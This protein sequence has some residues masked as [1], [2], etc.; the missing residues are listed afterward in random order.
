MLLGDDKAAD[1]AS[2]KLDVDRQN[3]PNGTGADPSP[4]TSLIDVC[5]SSGARE[6]SD[7]H[8]GPEPA[9]A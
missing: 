6:R 1:L 5:P 2:Q 9:N 8:E 7:G 4:S 3:Q